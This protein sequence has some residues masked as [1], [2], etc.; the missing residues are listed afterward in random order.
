MSFNYLCQCIQVG[1]GRTCTLC[2][3]SS[4]LRGS[5]NYVIENDE[6]LPYHGSFVDHQMCIQTTGARGACSGD[7]VSFILNHLII[8]L[9]V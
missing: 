7:A 5:E 3:T 9:F 2:Q 1:W 4:V 6:C 8:F